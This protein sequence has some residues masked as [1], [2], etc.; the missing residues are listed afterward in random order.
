MKLT[1]EMT[2]ALLD[3][4][5]E[6]SSN[7]TI[8]KMN[9]AVNIYGGVL[10]LVLN[11]YGPMLLTKEQILPLITDVMLT[12]LDPKKM[13]SYEDEF[14]DIISQMLSGLNDEKP[15]LKRG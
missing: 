3:D 14:Y 12:R 10:R 4:I 1:K 15:K 2:N 11:P 8:F 6:V 5:V 7:V 13:V 9:F